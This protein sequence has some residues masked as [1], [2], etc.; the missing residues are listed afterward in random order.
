MWGYEIHRPGE[1][2]RP[3]R[4][5]NAAYNVIHMNLTHPRLPRTDP[6]AEP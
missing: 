6:A 5:M 2:L 4:V 1:R 3:D